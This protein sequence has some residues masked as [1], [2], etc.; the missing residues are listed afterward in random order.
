MKKAFTLVELIGVITLLGL[1][2]IIVTPPI[3]NQIRNSEGKLDEATETLIYSATDLYIDSK[4]NDYPKNNDNIYC[5][6]LKELV[7]DGK[8]KEPIKTSKGKE[9]D[10]NKYVKITVT[11]NQYKYLITDECNSIKY[12][13]ILKSDN[14]CLKSKDI[15]PNGTKVNVQVNNKENYDFYVIK[16]TG[17]E[18]TL[19][20]NKNIGPTVAWITKEDYEAA[21]GTE[22][23][24]GEFGNN[25]KGPLTALKQLEDLTKG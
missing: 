25:N 19:I 11:N 15:C 3:I 2:M 17:S 1:I 20:M 22:S 13:S 18:L 10:L 14:N 9:I 16:D 6:T 8:L 5:V 12:N 21:G 4:K 7:D 23:D 24:Y